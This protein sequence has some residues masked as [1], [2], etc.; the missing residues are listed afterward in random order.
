MANEPPRGARRPVRSAP[1]IST[2]P[3][4][5]ARILHHP[6]E[7]PSV[8]AW[9]PAPNARP[10]QWAEYRSGRLGKPT[11]NRFRAVP[12]GSPETVRRVLAAQT[13][14]KM[15]EPFVPP[16]PNELER[17]YVSGIRRAV[18]GT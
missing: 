15:S 7:A 11:L 3:P 8:G 18:F 4:R 16:K 6:H 14:R 12:D 9:H 2:S 17:V 13:R 1:R 5:H 10:M